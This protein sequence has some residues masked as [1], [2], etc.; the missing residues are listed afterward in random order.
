MVGGR[1]QNTSKLSQTNRDNSCWLRGHLQ[2][3]LLSLHTPCLY[4]KRYTTP[5]SATSASHACPMGHTVILH[6]TKPPGGH[7]GLALLLRCFSMSNGAS[8]MR[9][10][11]RPRRGPNGSQLTLSVAKSSQRRCGWESL[12]PLCTG[13]SLTTV[14]EC[15]AIRSA[16]GQQET[17]RD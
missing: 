13:L 11:N 6:P 8:R 7:S 12:N 5:H 2:I 10:R 15:N 1:L 17:V 3:T 16:R 9:Q 4:H 14:L